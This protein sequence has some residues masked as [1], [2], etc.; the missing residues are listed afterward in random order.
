MSESRCWEVDRLA[1]RRLLS[2]LKIEAIPALV[3]EVAVLFAEHRKDSEHRVAGQVQSRLIRELEARSMQEFGR[4]NDYWANGFRAAEE[5]VASLSSNELLDQPS[6]KARSKGQVLR[7]I[8]R[9]ARKRSA[10]IERRSR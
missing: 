6:G 3:E 5:V 2:R 1:A 8:V 7:S 4:M 10:L 9:D